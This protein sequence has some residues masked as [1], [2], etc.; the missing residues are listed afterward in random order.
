M[1]S[2]AANIHTRSGHLHL[3]WD[4][5]NETVKRVGKDDEVLGR[6]YDEVVAMEENPL[7]PLRKCTSA[8]AQD[9]QEVIA[10]FS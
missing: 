2:L 7:P 1:A 8:V 6:Y 5:F 3:R 4:N 9:T 10:R